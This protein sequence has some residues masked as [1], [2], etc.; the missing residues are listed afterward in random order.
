MGKIEK[1]IIGIILIIV[2]II[3]G[4]N[5]LGITN[6][7]IFF[8]GWWT[9]FI[10][11]PSFIGLLKDPDKI[12]NLI[13]LAIGVSLLFIFNDVF[14]FSQIWSFGIPIVLIAI[15]IYFILKE[16]VYLNKSKIIEKEGVKIDS[17]NTQY[18]SFSSNKIKVEE[19]F[20]G[21]NLNATFG[22]IK[23]DLTNAKIQKD[24]YI[25]RQQFWFY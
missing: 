4:L 17:D 12:S 22:E 24:V 10:I 20:E 23:L 21:A 2:G 13:G 3:F 11:I 6:I 1:I 8:R 7:N 19:E 15:G 5:S 25:K 18:A 14:T 16:T 9:L